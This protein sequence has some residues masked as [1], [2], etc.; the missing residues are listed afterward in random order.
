MRSV[1]SFLG[2][3]FVLIYGFMILLVARLCP[4]TVNSIANN[5]NEIKS[6]AGIRL[7]YV[8]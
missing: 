7:Y 6:L 5:T 3:P 4:Y 1:E 2:G 8:E